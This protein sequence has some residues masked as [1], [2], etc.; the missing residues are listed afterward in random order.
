MDD[1]FYGYD[2]QGEDD[3]DDAGQS[4]GRPGLLGWIGMT[5]LRHGR[6]PRVSYDGGAPYFAVK[7]EESIGNEADN[8]DN[9][10]NGDGDGDGDDEDGEQAEEEQA[11]EMLEGYQ[12]RICEEFLENPAALRSRFL[13]IG[14][15][16]LLL[17]PFMLAFQTLHF[18]LSNL[19]EYHSRSKYL[20]PRVTSHLCRW[21]NREYNELPHELERRLTRACAI[22]EDFLAY[23][24]F[25]DPTLMS[26]AHITAY[27]S[28]AMASV[29]LLLSIYCEGA[30]VGLSLIPVNKADNTT[31]HNLLWILGLSSA[32][33]AASRAYTHPIN[34]TQSGG[35]GVGVEEGGKDGCGDGE[36]EKQ[37]EE[38]D[39]WKR[40]CVSLLQD[41]SRLMRL[42]VPPDTY[43]LSLHDLRFY[44]SRVCV[45]FPHRLQQF[46][47]ELLSVV[48]TPLVLLFTLGTEHSC[49]KI[50]SFVATHRLRCPVRGDVVA[51]SID[52]TPP[53][54]SSI[55]ATTAAVASESGSAKTEAG[56][57]AEED[58]DRVLLPTDKHMEPSFHD[59]GERPT[60]NHKPEN[61]R[62]SLLRSV[63]REANLEYSADPA[64]W[65]AVAEERLTL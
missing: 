12:F 14:V 52:T 3:V 53:K 28:G 9:D 23:P 2:D 31:Q 22:A 10:G 58:K 40:D 32:V 47:E 46:A 59:D 51:M 16:L 6:A 57:G 38:E 29:L 60:Q 30:L 41:W 13:T 34:N 27:L 33:Y 19:T 44:H 36:E 11:E 63:M 54:A 25:R 64:Y 56:T 50:I 37:E 5:F 39:Y 18:L 61:R 62:L 21:Q 65:R 43:P 20:G 48:N 17:M 49:Q 24:M 8:D 55:A 35:G 1:N 45:L 7:V 15:V 42:P 26:L 4:D